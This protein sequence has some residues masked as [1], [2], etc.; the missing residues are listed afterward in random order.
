MPSKNAGELARENRTMIER[1]TDTIKRLSED[2]K[3]LAE[4]V[5][6]LN[7]EM[8]EVV[9]ELKTIKWLAGGTLIVAAGAF[10]KSL[11]GF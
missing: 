4:A 1:N 5:R 10:V 9:G 2:V 6:T 11:F 7:R 8:G 3:P